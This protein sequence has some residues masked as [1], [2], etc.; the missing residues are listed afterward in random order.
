MTVYGTRELGACADDARE[1]IRKLNCLPQAPVTIDYSGFC[2]DC[3]SPK[4]MVGLLVNLDVLIRHL[5]P[6]IAFYPHSSTELSKKLIAVKF[7]MRTCPFNGPLQSSFH[8]KA[9]V[10]N[11]CFH[12]HAC[13]NF[14]LCPNAFRMRYDASSAISC[15]SRALL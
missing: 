6:R 2:R 7:R 8:I 11:Y 10:I 9:E 4:L 14:I 15:A 3:G 1:D 13:Q 5:F 12:L